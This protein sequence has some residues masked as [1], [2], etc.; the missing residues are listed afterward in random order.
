VVLVSACNFGFG[1]DEAETPPGPAQAAIYAPPEN[2]KVLVGGPLQVESA[3][4]GDVSRVELAVSQAGAE[5]EIVRSDRPND[6]VVVQE[7]LPTEPGV[8]TIQVTAVN[9]DGSQNPV[10]TRQVEVVVSQALSGEVQPGLGQQLTEPRPTEVVAQAVVTPVPAPASVGDE[11]AAFVVSSTGAEGV[12]PTE[13]LRYPPPPPAPGVPPGPTQADLPPFIPP[14]CDAAEYTGVFA[15]QTTS[16]R[17]F[18]TEPDDVAPEAVGGT[19]LHRAWRL[20]NT[21]TCTWGPGYELAFYGGRSMGSGG[22]AFE[23]SFPTEVARR[24]ALIDNNR[25]I[26]PEG[27]PNQTAILEVLLTA[28]TTPGIH[29]SYWRMRNPHGVFFGPI[30]GVTIEVVRDCA[31]G[32]YGAP[33]INRFV[34]LGV[35]D[36]FEPTD[37]TSVVAR[38]GEDLVLEWDIINATNF[39]IVFQGPTGDIESVSTSDPNSRATFPTGQLGN[40][41]ITLFADNGICTAEHQ[42]NV[43]VVPRE[44]DGFRANVTFA[45]NAPVTT[46]DANASF[47]SNVKP[48]TFKVDWQ[49]FDD[50][51]DEVILHI[52]RFRKRNVSNC[53]LKEWLGDLLCTESETWQ[54][55]ESETI[56]VGRNASG[57][58]TLCRDSLDCRDIARNLPIELAT[59]NDHAFLIFCPASDAREEY[60]VQ[61]F[62]EARKDGGPAQPQF[63]NAVDVQC[64]TGSGTIGEFSPE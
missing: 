47:A 42:V 24:N 16:R 58:A 28:P 10:L 33:V 59:T 15:P 31:F 7:W 52:D 5:P 50:E 38:Q 55:V 17:V 34:I 3:H 61:F 41:V 51:V 12:A 2:V 19:L 45:S 30:M 32:I 60:G 36:V 54:K 23:S 9:A 27:K 8:Y 18:I 44:G 21:G 14:V 53:T 22:I 4:P 1:G 49:H 62:L 26:M 29:Q 40:H 43:K 64:T 57:A 39:D 11:G 25:L 46:S 56:S 6:G 13:V 35:G 20:Q 37:P 48:G 63:S